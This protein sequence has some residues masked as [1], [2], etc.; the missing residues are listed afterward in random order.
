MNVRKKRTALLTAAAAGILASGA[1]TATPAQAD[2][3]CNSGRLCLIE[4][5]GN[6]RNIDPDIVI[7]ACSVG[8]V[9][10]SGIDTARN[11]SNRAFSVWG[12]NGASLS[13]LDPGETIDY[14]PSA[15]YRFCRWGL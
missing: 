10:I 3:T 14:T 13:R 9:W 8:T 15:S 7:P 5:S 11:R 1:M 12:S 6:I 2:T 4:S